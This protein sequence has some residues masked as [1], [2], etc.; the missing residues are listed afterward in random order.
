VT[1]CGG[2]GPR[3][4]GDRGE[5]HL[6]RLLQAAGFAAE[7][8]PLSG[9]AGGRFSSDV[10]VPLLNVDRKIEMKV[11]SNGFA[12]LYKWLAG[13][14]LLVVKADRAEPLVVL[15]LRFAVEIAAAAERARGGAR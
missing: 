8:T 5:R 2:R 1:R 11:R 10:S 4:K 3:Q 7:R 14:D 13:A 15:P 6:V 12:Q 9:S